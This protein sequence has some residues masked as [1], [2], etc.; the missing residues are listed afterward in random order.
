[1]IE[2]ERRVAS[3]SDQRVPWEQRISVFADNVAEGMR[4]AKYLILFLFSFAYF[5]ATIFRASRKLFWF[6]EL[7][8]VYVS[9]LPE[10]GAVWAALRQGVDFNPPLFYV[11]TRFSQALFG[12]GHVAT[13]LPEIIGFWIFC[14]CLF[15]F[16]SVRASVLAGTISMLFPMVT[17]A[18][19]YGYEARPHGIVLGFCGM[20]LVCWQGAISSRRRGLWLTG[21]FFS[22][23]CAIAT[24]T[25]GV[26]L[27][28]PFVLAELSRSVARRRVDWVLCLAIVVPLSGVLLSL[29]LLR[30]SR[31]ALPAT[32]FPAR[33]IALAGSYQYHL[34]PATV[35]IAAAL[36]MYFVFSVMPSV[37]WGAPAYSPSLEM[38]EIIVVIAFVVMPV[39]A[40]VLA[41]LTGAPFLYRYSASTIL[42]FGCLIGILMAKRSVVG[43]CVVLFLVAQI[44]GSLLQFGLS[45]AVIEPSSSL[46]L[47]P[48]PSL[49]QKYEAMRAIPNQELPIVLLDSL[50]FLPLM[51]YAPADLA[52]RLVY[53]GDDA[54]FV[55]RAYAVLRQC[56]RAPGRFEILSEFLATNDSFI[57]VF[58]ARS[59]GALPDFIR[60]ATNVRLEAI[61]SDSSIYLVTLG[62]SR[63]VSLDAHQP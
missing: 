21:L 60:K 2:S 43:L 4:R 8:T 59:P 33:L 29:P 15:R 41:R 14:L 53:V 62:Q 39:F 17:T 38:P 22:L 48:M 47:A 25:Y 28:V 31:A 7:F 12:E 27:V 46:V 13:R 19:Y 30:A 24:H 9:R 49:T 58:N 23:L 50:E 5:A 35:V 16:V 51:H 54:D 20:A 34:A 3:A 26:L 42:G 18:Y 57:A 6:D 63:S 1:M 40:F 52:S 55:G 36:V 10:M 37:L 45:G 56:C 32:F 11:L 44:G 61:S